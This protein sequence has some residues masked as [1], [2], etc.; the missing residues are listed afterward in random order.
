MRTGIVV[1]P[2]SNCDRDVH[3]VLNDVMGINAQY[4][5]HTEESIDEYDALILPGGFSYGD[6]LRA[7][8]IAA[9]SPIVETIK[10]KAQ[11]GLPILGICNGFQILV[12]AGILPGALVKNVKL[13]FS[14]KWLKMEV[15]NVNTPFTNMFRLN[16]E[17]TIPIAHGEGRFVISDDKIP[18]LKQNNQIVFKYKD[19]NPNG[20]TEMI[21]AICNKEGNVMGLMPHPERAS[22]PILSPNQTKSNAGLIFRSLK[23][24]LSPHIKN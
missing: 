17:I 3:H 15:L 18:Q 23:N 24:F 16:D 12:E 19:Q 20:S 1:F 6:R 2:G 9:Q 8:V 5:W 11:E 14:C 13:K 7:G 22:E 4:I 10:K 21:A